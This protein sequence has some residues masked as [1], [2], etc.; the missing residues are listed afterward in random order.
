MHNMF[1][2]QGI[3]KKVELNM[4]N[5]SKLKLSNTEALEAAR[6]DTGA[7][8]ES[9]QKQFLEARKKVKMKG[10][11]TVPKELKNTFGGVAEFCAKN[12]R[13]A[14]Q[15]SGDYGLH[16]VWVC[17]DPLINPETQVVGVAYSTE[18]LL[19]NAYRQTMYGLPSIV[20]VDTTHRLVIEGHN[21]M[22]F[23]T[24][25]AAQHFHIIGYGLC[26]KEDTAMHTYVAKCLK[27]AME[28]IV[29]E[30]MAKGEG[31]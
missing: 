29:Q 27:D 5:P 2:A 26:S 12:S 25:D 1:A 8:D 24:T 6:F 18:N 16:A 14:L 4:S 19:L 22:L 10:N 21:N 30:R 17:G 23:G 28:L 7:L 9:Q 13:A 20:Q 11:T 3:S 31:I 15:A